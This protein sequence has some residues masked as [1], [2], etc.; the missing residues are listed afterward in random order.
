MHEVANLCDR[1]GIIAHGRMVTE[2]VQADV[3]ANA[4]TDNM[5][6]AFVHYAYRD[7]TSH[8]AHGVA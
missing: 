2:G 4:K 3:I 7:N 5:E 6:D 1:V 8:S